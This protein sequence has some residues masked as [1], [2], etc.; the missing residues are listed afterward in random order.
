MRHGIVNPI[1]C[2]RPCVRVILSVTVLWRIVSVYVLSRKISVYCLSHL[3]IYPVVEM[4]LPSRHFLPLFYHC[5]IFFLL[6]SLHFSSFLGWPFTRYHLRYHHRYHDR[7]N[8]HRRRSIYFVSTLMKKD[9]RRLHTVIK[10]R[11]FNKNLLWSTLS[12]GVSFLLILYESTKTVLSWT[13]FLFL[14]IFLLHLI[15]VINWERSVLQR[16]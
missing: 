8:H 5:H 9:P 15:W 7:L 10:N 2:L 1:P 4:S 16:C 13:I 6:P 11:T 3:V 12:T 14:K